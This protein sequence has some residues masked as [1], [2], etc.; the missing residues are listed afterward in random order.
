ME[1]LVST[2]SATVLMAG[3]ASATYIANRA[4]DDE[5]LPVSAD[6]RASEA[7]SQLLCDLEHALA[8][9]ERTSAAV[10]FTVPDRDGDNAPETVRYAFSGAAGDPLTYEYNGG[11]A[12]KIADD[13]QAFDLN[14]LTRIAGAP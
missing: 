4:L 1:L 12:V 10:T 6:R 5:A 2:A 7:L 13:V 11:P 14:Y 3:L 8:F 9:S